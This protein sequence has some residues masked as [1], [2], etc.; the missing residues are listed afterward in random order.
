MQKESIKQA[1]SLVE[2]SIVTLVV[3][4]LI[5]VIIGG[6]SLIGNS[7]I[8]SARSATLGSQ[9][10]T[11]PGMVLWLESSTND[12]F[13][14][15]QSV[16]GAQIS[17]WYNIDPANFTSQNNLTTSPS[18]AVTY[19]ATGIGNIPDVNITTGGKMTLTNFYQDALNTSTVVI[20]F[21]PTV[22]I[23]ASS[24]V[25]ADSGASGNT[26]CSIGIQSNL[27]N[28]NAGSSVNSST[29]TNP[30]SFVINRQYILMVYF[31]GSSSKVFSNNITEVGG[32][33]ATLNPGTNA[34]DGLTIGTDKSGSNG[35]SAEI[36][37]VIIYNRVL[38][39]SERT[40][41]MNYLSKKYKIPVTGI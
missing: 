35:L 32:S 11:I 8:S 37:E 10:T 4:L 34:L 12:S 18:S 17:T 6:S 3:G 30:A 9:I 21:Q 33:G 7:R 14:N 13:S 1:F 41:V 31:N 22:A 28:L 16:D 15:I 29:V 39:D 23:G 26:T 27:V 5:A 40:D 19:K 24:L 36:S 38:K 25:I 2:L 20:V